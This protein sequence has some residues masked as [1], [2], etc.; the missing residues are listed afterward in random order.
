MKQHFTRAAGLTVLAAAVAAGLAFA[1]GESGPNGPGGRSDP[2]RVPTTPVPPTTPDAADRDALP[3][4][5]P[6]PPEASAPDAGTGSSSSMEPGAGSSGTNRME[7]RPT[8]NAAS[9]DGTAMDPSRRDM[10]APRADRN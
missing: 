2:N 1:Q 3:G 10:R 9:P 7:S 5:T 6:V 4:I 8:P